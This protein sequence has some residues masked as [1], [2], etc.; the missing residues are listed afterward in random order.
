MRPTD[1]SAPPL[2]DARGANPASTA[3]LGWLLTGLDGL[4]IG[5]ALFDAEGQMLYANQAGRAHLQ[6]QGGE[7]T[8]ATAPGETRSSAVPRSWSEVLARV[9]GQGHRLMIEVGGAEQRL[10]VALTPVESDAQ[11]C[12]LAVFGRREL[13]GSVELQMFASSCGLT[14]TEHRVLDQLTQGLSTVDIARRNGVAQSTVLTHVAAI[15][16]KT[17]SRSVRQLINTLARIPPLAPRTLMQ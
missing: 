17:S 16:S 7:L 9:C 1:F 14:G 3:P 2:A 11:R 8:P 10:F 4:A 6:A 13:T 12:A 5:L 15:R